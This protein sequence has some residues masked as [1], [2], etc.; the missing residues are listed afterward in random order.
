M[1]T[2]A[3]LTVTRTCFRR[4]LTLAAVRPSTCAFGWRCNLSRKHASKRPKLFACTVALPGPPPTCLSPLELVP[5]WL[6]ETG[7]SKYCK[8]IGRLIPTLLFSLAHPVPEQHK[9][10][11]ASSLLVRL[12]IP[13]DHDDAPVPR[14]HLLMHFRQS[15]LPKSSPIKW[16]LCGPRTRSAPSTP[17]TACCADCRDL[18]GRFLSQSPS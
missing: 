17:C 11:P 15:D 14:T 10:L 9:C 12:V 2:R 8:P 7:G 1:C 5:R 4:P 16:H 6:S 13:V 3:S 18:H